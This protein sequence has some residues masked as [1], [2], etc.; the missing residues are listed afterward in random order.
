MDNEWFIT[1]AHDIPTFK[2]NINVVN[3]DF[4]YAAR[5]SRF[6]VSH[7]RQISTATI[8]DGGALRFVP[9]TYNFDLRTLVM[10]ASLSG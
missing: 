1:K 7:M 4:G 9:L 10:G 3:A 6:L 2:S 5:R 8:A